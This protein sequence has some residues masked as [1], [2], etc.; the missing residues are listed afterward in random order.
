MLSSFLKKPHSAFI[1]KPVSA[2]CFVSIVVPVR[3]EAENL[4]KTLGAFANQKDFKNAPLDPTFFE[5]IVLVNNCRDNS[6]EIV[7]NW[8][9]ENINFNFHFAEINLP[10]ENAN[11]G[12]VRRLLMN[13]AYFRLESN[14]YKGGIIATTD[15]DTRVTSDWISS[16]VSEIENG[17]D[18]VGG[19]ILIDKKEFESL[20]EMTR[21]FHLL[22]EEYRLLAAEIE[23][24]YDRL[25]H[26][27]PPRHHQHFNGSFA[28][29][30]D[31][32]E[33]AG[34][35]PD[36][37]FLEDVAFYNALSRIDAK[38]RHSPNVKVYTSA[39]NRGRTALGLSTQLKEWQIMGKNGDEYLVESAQTIEKKIK[40]RRELRK[41]WQN[42]KSKNSF[43]SSVTDAL[44]E[45]LCIS[46]V[47]LITVLENSKTFGILNEKIIEEQNA[48]DKWKQENPLVSVQKAIFD[49]RKNFDSLPSFEEN[50]KLVQPERIIKFI[51]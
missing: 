20:D 32:F 22:D 6:A 3:D 37:K 42:V 14:K 40:A 34:G 35:I 15:G 44:A 33:R 46:K 16:T 4:S 39:R 27:S 10:D 43:E 18:A 31:A 50:T 47:N 48:N 17:A 23:N 30:T 13:E 11:I 24:F 12:F 25:P 9:R 38:I 26:D 49:L 1:K 45:K 5:V 8:Q 36:V 7:E 51:K 21:N 28:V 2:Q 29:T 41:L 19:R